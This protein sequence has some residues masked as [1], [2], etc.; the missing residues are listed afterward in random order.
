VPDV[1]HD[2]TGRGY[3]WLGLPGTNGSPGLPGT[4]V[5]FLEKKFVDFASG[6]VILVTCIE[7]W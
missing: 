4:T 3:T 1:T 5:L 2:G 7:S 6:W